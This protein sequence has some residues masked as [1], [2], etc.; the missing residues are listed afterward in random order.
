MSSTDDSNNNVVSGD[1][2]F[3][4]ATAT[5][6]TVDTNL[7]AHWLLDTGDGVIASDKT[8]HGHD[9]ILIN[10][11]TWNDNKVLFDGVDD[12]I[13]VGMLD[14][15]GE[16]LTLTGW[17][18]ADNLAN[19]TY[20]DCRILSKATGTATQDHYWMIS[21]IKV[22][23]ETRLR[24]RL[25]AGGV[26]STL[27]ATSGNLVNDELFHVAAVYDGHTMRLYKNG[28]EIGS[29]AKTGAIETNNT[30]ELWIGANPTVANARPWNGL[31]SDVRVYQTAL[32]ALE[33][34]AM[35]DDDL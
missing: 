7:V 28:I 33:V 24:F 6:S 4:T 32:T 21:T 34:N 1:L 35:M 30:T 10:G 22:G 17:V 8:G 23:S 19:C 14:V 27:V 26:T 31:I 11:V 25:K 15:A 13:N 9:G 2:T 12:Y 16:E 18:Q 3:T 5:A 29:L 20:R